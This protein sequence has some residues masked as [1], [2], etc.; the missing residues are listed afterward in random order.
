V[1]AAALSI[2]TILLQGAAP[3]PHKQPA[4][5]KPIESLS[6]AQRDSICAYQF[7]VARV[8]SE[9]TLI[10]EVGR[11]HLFAVRLDSTWSQAL[12][13]ALDIDNRRPSRRD[14]GEPCADSLGMPDVIHLVYRDGGGHR[15][16]LLYRPVYAQLTVGGS[17]VW[18]DERDRHGRFMNLLIQDA[19]A[20][21]NG[22]IRE[23]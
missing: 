3:P 14:W 10:H 11:H 19:F 13:Q 23:G 4:A 2:C 16:N 7:A 9:V 22:T 6:P 15:A 21:T 8:C 20:T 18:I 17:T 5:H 1:A 12:L